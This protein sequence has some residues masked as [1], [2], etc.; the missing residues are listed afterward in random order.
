M[1]RHARHAAN[2]LLSLLLLASK[3]AAEVVTLT[4]KEH[5]EL[6][7]MFVKVRHA[8]FVSQCPSF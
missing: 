4:D 6:T 7:D 2:S 1:P 5:P 8:R 3:A